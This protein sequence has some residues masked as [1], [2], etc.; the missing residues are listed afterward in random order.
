MSPWKIGNPNSIAYKAGYFGWPLLFPPAEGDEAAASI[1][2]RVAQAQADRG[3]SY[4]QRFLTPAEQA[5]LARAPNLGSR[6]LGQAVHRATDAALSADYPG[7]FVYSTRGVDFYDT[8]TGAMIELT[9]P[10]Q[11]FSH[12]ARGGAYLYAQYATYTLP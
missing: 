7:R 11:V 12:L 2:S 9:T 4:L 3:V 1:I 10:G 6:F 8:T 5:A